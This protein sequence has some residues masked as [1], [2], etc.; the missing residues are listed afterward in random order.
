MTRLRFSAFTASLL[1]LSTGLLAFG[2]APAFAQT[3]AEIDRAVFMDGTAAFNRH[4]LDVF[5]PTVVVSASPCR[6]R[7]GGCA[8]EARADV[9]A[10]SANPT[11]LPILRSRR[12]RSAR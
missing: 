1:T 9:V 7:S 5:L 6:P 10:K 12:L 3:T 8:A 2:P 11:R 4:E